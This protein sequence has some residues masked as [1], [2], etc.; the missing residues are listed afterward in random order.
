LA[1]FQRDGEAGPDVLIVLAEES[2][3]EVVA[4]VNTVGAERVGRVTPLLERRLS[5]KCAT[6]RT[7][8]LLPDLFPGPC[9]GSTDPTSVAA[10][11]A[12]RA[13]Y[14]FF[15]ALN[16]FDEMTIDWDDFDNDQ[17]DAS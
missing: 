8:S 9:G 2:A 13:K 3:V 12:E 14:R 4:Y 1:G 7:S 16:A 5:K 10:C 11:A 17:T 15:Q 6:E